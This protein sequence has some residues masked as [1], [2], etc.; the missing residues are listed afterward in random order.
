MKVYLVHSSIDPKKLSIKNSPSCKWIMFGESF[1]EFQKWE[2]TFKGKKMAR[3]EVE[4]NIHEF[5]MEEMRKLSIW[6]TNVFGTH[7]SSNDEFWL[8]PIFEKNGWP[9]KIVVQKGLWRIIEEQLQK[10]E[11]EDLY[12]VS[13]SRYILSK[14]KQCRREGKK[15]NIKI[16]G[17][18]YFLKSH[19]NLYLGCVVEVA[20]FLREIIFDKWYM[21]RFYRPQNIDKKKSY[22][23]LR[24]SPRD[25]SFLADGSFSDAYFPGL[26]ESMQKKN[27]MVLY[28]LNL[29]VISDKKRVYQ[30]LSRNKKE[31][32]WLLESELKL[33]D[34]FKAIF[35]SLKHILFLH[36]LGRGV[37]DNLESLCFREYAHNYLK[38]LVPKKI[39][40]SGINV[41]KIIFFWENK[42]YEK[43]MCQ[44]AKNYLPEC[45]T[46]GFAHTIFFP[47]DPSCNYSEE[48][49]K[50]MPLPNKIITCGEYVYEWLKTRA[51]KEKLLVT[52][53]ALR[54]AYLRDRPDVIESKDYDRTILVA[55][56]LDIDLSAELLAFIFNFAE[57]NTLYKFII[58]LHPVLI[59]SDY[60]SK[61]K[62]LA[63]KN[64]SIEFSNS[65]LHELFAKS[66]YFLYSGP[67]TVACEAL[68]LGKKVLKYVSK[69]RYTTDCLEFKFSD[70]QE[71]IFSNEDLLNVKSLS[72]D[73]AENNKKLLNYIFN[74]RSINDLETMSCF[75]DCMIGESYLNGGRMSV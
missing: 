11:I 67:T 51:I 64:D 46:I 34:Y 50:I 75:Y 4:K 36:R 21:Y 31:E 65:P 29:S 66:E 43:Y 42:A 13:S 24:T 47:F 71:L 18:Y 23:L 70:K 62:K 2:D 60:I 12:I 35:L 58:K 20:H 1:V 52:G 45:S 59:K 48:E 53:P 17:E 38:A 61:F 30:W 28:Q 41:S 27:I 69:I 68:V 33:S 6:I 10:N 14:I 25:V 55:L 32:F 7:K 56:P 49:A 39:K 3:I 16:I 72:V 44:Q 73:D 8:S 9:P 15:H 40:Q 74:V 5:S 26:K 54:H 22:V 57:K 19:I 63:K 37:V